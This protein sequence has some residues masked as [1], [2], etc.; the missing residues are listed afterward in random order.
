MLDS[1]SWLEARV[2]SLDSSL[3]PGASQHLWDG[4]DLQDI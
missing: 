1:G 3:G 2:F 4:F